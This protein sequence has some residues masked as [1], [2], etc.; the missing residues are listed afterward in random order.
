MNF[1]LKYLEA[2]QIHGIFLNNKL[3]DEVS[4][5]GIALY[6]YLNDNKN[7]I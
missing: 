4:R 7:I 3:R 6:G 1:T 5:P 2:Y